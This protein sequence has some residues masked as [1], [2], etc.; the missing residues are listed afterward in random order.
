MSTEA[1]AT[2]AQL[3]AHCGARK[4]NRDELALITAP[5]STKT[6]KPIAHIEVVNAVIETLGFRRM[7]VIRDE[8]AVSNDGM[9]M[10]GVMDLE[11]EFYGCRFSVGLRNSNDKS[12]RL[13][14]TIG[15]RVMVCDNMSFHGD[16][17][18][19]LARH[20]ASMNIIDLVSIG[21]DKMQRNFEPLRQ[22]VDFWQTTPISDNEARL[23]IYG[24][25]IDKKLQAPTRL[26]PHVHSLYFEDDRFPAGRIWRLA[27][28]FTSAFKDLDPI[29]QFQATAKIGG[30]L[31]TCFNTP[32]IW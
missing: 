31:S 15:Y 22:L 19:V 2:P 20:S 17:S 32:S 26:M 27:N 9:K 23:A 11:E 18:P 5:E 14:L 10:F 21:V 7:A 25:F 6:H 12:M 13:A 28:A 24:A 4:I 29:P 1:I 16:F 8:Y 30:F 3:I